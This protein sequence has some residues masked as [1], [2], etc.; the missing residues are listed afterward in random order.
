MSHINWYFIF[1]EAWG[2]FLFQLFVKQA[3]KTVDLHPVNQEILAEI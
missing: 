1:Y 3:Y 2:I